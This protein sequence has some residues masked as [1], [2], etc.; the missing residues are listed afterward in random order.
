MERIINNLDFLYA[1]VNPKFCVKSMIKL[2]DT[3]ELLSIIECTINVN[4][5]SVE[6][7]NPTI[8]ILKYLSK[9]R[10]GSE[11]YLTS[12]HIRSLL[13]RN[14]LILRDTISQALEEIIVCSIVDICNNE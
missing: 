3:E 11:H 2:A 10:V 12:T 13:T 6:S 9:F 7:D 4:F 14:S 1:I 5:F 8:G